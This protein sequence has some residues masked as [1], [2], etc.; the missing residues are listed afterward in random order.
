[1]EKKS[2]QVFCMNENSQ[3]GVVELSVGKITLTP[4]IFLGSFVPRGA[5]YMFSRDA[6]LKSGTIVNCPKCGG[7]LA[8]EKQGSGEDEKLRQ[9]RAAARN[10]ATAIAQSMTTGPRDQK[11]VE[12]VGRVLNAN[13]SDNCFAEIVLGKTKLIVE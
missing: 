7:N 6:R 2:V 3:I 4:T 11:L 12:P 10:R 8:F 1:M 13:S 5:D 9:A